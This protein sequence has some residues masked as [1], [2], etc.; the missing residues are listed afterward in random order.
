MCRW[1]EGACCNHYQ[2]HK[3]VCVAPVCNHDSTLT[4]SLNFRHVDI[5][6]VFALNRSGEVWVRIYALLLECRFC[7]LCI[8]HLRV[9]L[10][11]MFPQ[12]LMQ[13]EETKH[14]TTLTRLGLAGYI[15]QIENPDY[16][17][18]FPTAA[19]FEDNINEQ[20]RGIFL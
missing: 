7:C 4:I 17:V 16:A 14:Q 9:D 2:V 6:N 18:T 11:H 1:Q 13:A 10:T 8:K 3:D 20:L 15:S 19:R 12:Q 5:N